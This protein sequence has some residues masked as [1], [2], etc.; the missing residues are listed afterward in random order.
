MGNLRIGPC[1]AFVSKSGLSKDVITRS[2]TASGYA[3]GTGLATCD[4][5]R[6]LEEYRPRWPWRWR[7]SVRA[8]ALLVVLL[9]VGI[10]A[11]A[12]AYS[13]V[14]YVTGSQ[15]Y[16]AC[17]QR[18]AKEKIDGGFKEVEADNP[19]QA[20]LWASC[21]PIMAEN[22]DN[23]G[24]AIGS[25]APEAPADAKALASACPDGYKEMPAFADHWYI[26][27]V[28]AI[29]KNGGPSL[30]DRVAPAGWLI[31]RAMKARWPRCVDYVAKAR[32][33]IS[34]VTQ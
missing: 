26:V 29:E 17:R 7:N 15:F 9:L 25:S 2:R 8:R 1:V 34:P 20:L 16:E 31:E 18:Q 27:A 21:T 32:K 19:S 13:G 10:G 12:A 3:D 11:G 28:E 4:Q 23:A 22:M 30:I 24:F 33:D 14:F 5:A 6:G